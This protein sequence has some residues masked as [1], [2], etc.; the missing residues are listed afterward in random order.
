MRKLQTWSIALLL[1]V[2]FATLLPFAASFPGNA[3]LLIGA[4]S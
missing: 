1:S 2:A 3:D 4:F